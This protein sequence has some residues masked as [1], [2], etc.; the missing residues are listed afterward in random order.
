MP[1]RIKEKSIMYDHGE[2]H[3]Q[4]TIKALAIGLLALSAQHLMAHT[5]KTFF[6]TRPDGVNSY[7]ERITLQ[8]MT[9]SKAEDSFGGT[10]QATAFY[11]ESLKSDDLARYFY[12]GDKAGSAVGRDTL[13]LIIPDHLAVGAI[14]PGAPLASAADTN[15]KLSPTVRSYGLM[16]TYY[17]DLEKILPG[18]YFDIRV[19]VVQVET[20]LGAIATGGNSDVA[21]QYLGGTLTEIPTTAAEARV[22]LRNAKFGGKRQALGIADIDLRMG[23]A[24]L[25]SSRGSLGINVGLTVPTG[26]QADSKFAFDA[27]YGNSNH[28]GFGAG[29]EGRYQFWNNEDADL[30]IHANADYR[31]LFTNTERRTLG[32]KGIEWGQYRTVAQ[33]SA[34]SANVQA[35]PAANVLTQSVDVT[36]GTQL[37]NVVGLTYNYGGLTLDIGYNLYYRDRDSVKLRDA[38]DDTKYVYATND[39]AAAGVAA[40]AAGTTFGLGGVTPLN[41]TV[42]SFAKLTNDV[43]DY[44]VARAPIQIT[45]KVMGGVGYVFKDWQYPLMLGAGANYDIPVDNAAV[46]SWG[47]FLKTGIAF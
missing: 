18:L 4:R 37:D 16:M 11:N 9:S 23:Y 19:P 14:A 29:L 39:G 40:N 2:Y 36:P 3:M 42:A 7:L 33:V 34:S 35:T 10:F 26:N 13:R 32:I 44:D 30:S 1:G 21:K 15:V 28:W 6:A 31:Q 47:F 38:W 27:I 5:N 8:S 24:F 22:P 46:R 45:N 20:D 25:Q 12:F 43:I 17:Q 41:G